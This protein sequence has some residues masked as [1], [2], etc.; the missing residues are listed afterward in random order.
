MG[1][2]AVVKGTPT[3]YNKD[4]QECWELLFDTVS[5]SSALPC[6]HSCLGAKLTP[7]RSGGL[8]SG[9]TTCAHVAGT[10][11][12]PSTKALFPQ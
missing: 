8:G 7:A 2:M 9:Q 4:F 5:P 1:C 10:Q 12:V 3:T 11:G 6:A